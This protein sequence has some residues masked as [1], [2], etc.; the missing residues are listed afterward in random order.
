MNYTDDKYFKIDFGSDFEPLSIPASNNPIFVTSLTN[1]FSF[2]AGVLNSVVK[3]RYIVCV[4][5]K[6]VNRIS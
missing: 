5:P 1:D 2:K 4:E 3:G 6:D